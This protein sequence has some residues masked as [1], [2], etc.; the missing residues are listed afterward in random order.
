M[1]GTTAVIPRYQ[2]SRDGVPLV[3]GTLET[4]LAG[5]TTPTETWANKAL[6]S[7]NGTSITL[8]ANGECTLW[9]D[10]T[11][12]Y[13]FVLKN[14]A[15]VTQW[16]EDNVSGTIASAAGV[17]Y[18]SGSVED[19]LD[20]LSL[21]S[22]TALRAYTGTSKYVQITGYL[23]TAN[24]S[25]TAGFFTRDDSDTTS[26]DNG[27]TIIVSSDDTRWKRVYSGMIEARW[28]GAVGDGT[29]H[30]LSEYF[31]SLAEAQAIYPH[32]A[33]LTDEMDWAAI[34]AAINYA[35]SLIGGDVYLGEG[36][37]L[38]NKQID[39][40]ESNVTLIGAGQ[41][42]SAT[43]LASTQNSA[44]TRIVWN[45]AASTSSAVIEFR[46]L[47]A[48]LL[49]YG[50]GL[51]GLMIDALNLAGTGLRV[52]TWSSAHFSDLCVYAATDYAID[53]TTTSY[54]LTP[55]GTQ[56]V[57]RCLFENINTFANNYALN[58][59]TALR[60]GEDPAS[61]EAANACFNRFLGCRFAKGPANTGYG[62]YL[63][64]TDNN[65]FFGCNTPEFV[66]GSTDESANGAA[67]YNM[68]IACEADIICKASQTGGNSSN[69][70]LILGLNQSNTAGDVTIE[71][72]AGG[73]DDADATVILSD[74]KMHLP[75]GGTT[76]GTV[77]SSRLD[78]F[79]RGSWT[80]AVVG[81]TSAGTGT[82]T[83]RGG[84]YTRIGD[85]VYFKGHVDMTAHTGT[86][87]MTIEGLP[88]FAGADSV[89]DT[90]RV[91][92][93][94]LTF[95]GQL[96]G[97]IASGTQTISLQVM[98]SGSSL[99]LLAMDTSAIVYVSGTY[100]VGAE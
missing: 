8:D 32:A 73:S 22:Y 95:T 36:D 5:T 41:G 28:F 74:G 7:S 46:T 35:G 23:V 99:S 83:N 45:A 50:G 91:R 3:G 82:Y 40:N 92:A 25:A 79:E 75:K 89:Q 9:L 21:A 58:A 60:L 98:S 44:A 38:T 55:G 16:T 70:N 80:P 71:T 53:L 64:N 69:N 59:S 57:Q 49:Q 17:T 48:D 62:V 42:G 72:G 78:V 76:T 12:V 31:A 56:N 29:S 90:V 81:T 77:S 68:V 88:Y 61:V 20:A 6:T 13:K 11:K 87:N 85:V 66:F 93:G 65:M 52:V 2:F 18:G 26:A 84:R 34:K 96:T 10:D 30:P 94:S 4:Y 33:A 19:Q 67:R 39:I 14:A 15:G 24:P 43:G 63:L 100:W 1:S 27:G 97:Y 54:S 37:F 51:R 86:G 47:Q